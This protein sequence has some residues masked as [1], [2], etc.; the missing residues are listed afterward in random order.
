MNESGKWINLNFIIN[1]IDEIYIIF[2]AVLQQ[3]A[4]LDSTESTH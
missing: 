2:V 3:R 4:T 1:F